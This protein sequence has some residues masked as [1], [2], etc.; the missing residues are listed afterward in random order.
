MLLCYTAGANGAFIARARLHPVGLVA[1]TATTA[2]VGRFYISTVAAGGTTNANTN[3]WAE[4]ACPAQTAAQ[5]TTATS[6]IEVPFGIA[7]APTETILFSMHHAA[8]ANTGWDVTIVG[9]DY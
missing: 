7:I 9:G 5:T 1:A 2:T 4:V 6:Y 3:L 8:A